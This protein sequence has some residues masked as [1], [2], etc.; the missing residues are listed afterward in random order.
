MI[1]LAVSTN[2]FNEMRAALTMRTSC[3]RSVCGRRHYRCSHRQLD[4][5]QT[6][7]LQVH[8]NRLYHLRYLGRDPRRGG[9]CRYVP[10]R[11]LP[12]RCWC[13]HDA[14]HCACIYG[15][16]FSLHLL[17]EGSLTCR[18]VGIVA[19]EAKRS[20][21]GYLSTLLLTYF[22]LD[23]QLTFEQGSHG[24]L[25]VCGYVRLH[26]KHISQWLEANLNV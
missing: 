19:C 7:P 26:L 4:S 3:Q 22:I 11:P 8:S 14:S 15:Q 9:S 17:H 24:V 18:I 25:I 6:W 5:Q 12:E 1:S 21:D 10:C 2:G 23:I 20:N 16:F 13:R